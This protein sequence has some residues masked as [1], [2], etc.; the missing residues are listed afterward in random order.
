MN[1]ITVTKLYDLLTVKAGKDA[2]EN[3]NSYIDKKIKN[4]FDDFLKILATRENLANLKG[5]LKN[6]IASSKTEISKWM[7]IFWVGQIA[8]T[9]GFILLFMNK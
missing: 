2:A 8:V 4:E 9:F 3:L 5:G 6:K 1:T 7:F